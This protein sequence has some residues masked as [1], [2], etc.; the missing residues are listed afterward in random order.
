[1]AI[2]LI[3]W[4]FFA[5]MLSP[6]FKSFEVVTLGSKSNRFA[7]PKLESD[8]IVVFFAARLLGS[9]KFIHTAFIIYISN[10]LCY[11]RFSYDSIL[12][13]IANAFLN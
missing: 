5:A 6:Y 7:I 4:F 2:G 3:Q 11:F 9:T 8:W 12:V 1:M 10:L 13:N